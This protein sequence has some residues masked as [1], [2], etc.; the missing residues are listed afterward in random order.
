MQSTRARNI[1]DKEN[2]RNLIMD[3]AIEIFL[4][5]SGKMPSATQIARSSSMTKSNLYTYFKSK[6]E[7]FY[8]IL[9]E[10]YNNWF[11]GVLRLGDYSYKL[12][13]RLFE[14]FYDNELHVK[15]CSLYHSSIKHGLSEK[16]KEFLEKL[17]RD[18]LDKLTTPISNATS[19]SKSEIQILLYSSISLIIGAYHFEHEYES[20]FNALKP[21]DIYIPRLKVMWAI[22]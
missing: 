20:G 21:E 9:I 22:H 4:S 14:S 6:E 15:L 7:L 10:Q 3:T 11:E 2:K 19:M 5:H 1:H 17:V 13:S 8:E 12:E 18:Q 16:Q